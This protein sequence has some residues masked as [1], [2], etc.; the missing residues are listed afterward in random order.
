M[1]AAIST[2]ILSRRSWA[3]TCSAM[4]SRSRLNKTR[5]PPDALRICQHPPPRGQ[6]AG[7]PAAGDKTKKNNNFIHSAPPGALQ[8]RPNQDSQNCGTVCGS[9]PIRPYSELRLVLPSKTPARG[10]TASSSPMLR[11]LRVIFSKVCCPRAISVVQG[12]RL[13]PSHRERSDCEAI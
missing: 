13:H 8:H 5:G 4:V 11:P 12:T 6:P 3:E 1:L 7:W 9:P 10:D 2:T